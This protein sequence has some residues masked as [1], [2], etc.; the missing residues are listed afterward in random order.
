MASLSKWLVGMAVV[1]IAS[2]TCVA[3]EDEPAAPKHTIKDVMTNAHKEG[4]LK[5]VLSGDASQQEKLILLDHYV[6]L[7]EN[8]PPKGEKASWS[9]KTNAI[10]VAAAKVAVGRDGSLDVLK[11]TTN[12]AACHKVHK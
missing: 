3:A 7:A 2:W 11:V 4:L 12:C 10:V 9:D 1:V 6:S 5:K 8:T